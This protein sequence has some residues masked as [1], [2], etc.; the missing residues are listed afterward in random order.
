MGDKVVGKLEEVGK[1]R[2]EVSG[3]RH[4]RINTLDGVAINLGYEVLSY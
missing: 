1:K 2:G 3:E 4:Q